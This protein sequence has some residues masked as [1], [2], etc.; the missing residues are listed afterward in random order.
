MARKMKS[1]LPIDSFIE[2]VRNLRGQ[3]QTAPFPLVCG[4]VPSGRCGG[5]RRANG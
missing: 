1:L 3:S 5:K 2:I 4:R